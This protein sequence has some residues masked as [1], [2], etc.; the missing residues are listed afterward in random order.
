MPYALDQPMKPVYT[1]YCW[2]KIFT[3]E[4][5]DAIIKLGTTMQEATVAVDQ[6]V[7][8]VD[9]IKRRSKVQWVNW[10]MDSDWI[11]A[12][13]A[14][15]TMSANKFF[16]FILSSYLEPLQLTQY[17]ASYKG[18]YDWHQDTGPNAMTKRK[19]SQVVLLSDPKGFKG[20]ELELFDI[21]PIK[22]LDRGVV[23]TFPPYEFHKVHP[24]TEG[25]RWSLVS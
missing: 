15:A 23:I 14:G 8:G 22:E 17:D 7:I 19:L 13:L 6:N 10:N 4:E 1:R 24:L 21:G 20:G 16:N 2:E 18:H 3:P 11:Y 5:C 12:K 25:T 9:Q